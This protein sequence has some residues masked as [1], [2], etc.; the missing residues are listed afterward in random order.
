MNDSKPHLLSVVLD[1][2]HS[3]VTLSP[4]AQERLRHE[5]R[6]SVKRAIW[7]LVPPAF[8]FP[9]QGENTILVHTEAPG[10]LEDA[11][12]LAELLRELKDVV[13]DAVV[14]SPPSSRA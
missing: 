3:A 9:D 12:A 13:A 14:I 6:Q 5:H 10:S 8:I 4:S 2:P 11:H 1:Q 7:D